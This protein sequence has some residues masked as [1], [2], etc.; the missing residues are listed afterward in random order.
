MTELVARTAAAIVIG[1]ELLSGK[2]QDANVI[3]LARTLRGLGVRLARV[4]TVPDDPDVIAAEVKALRQHVDLVLTSGGVGPTHDDVTIEAVARAFGVEVVVHPELR[5][6]LED[7]YRERCTEHHL[8]MA[9]VPAGAELVGTDGVHWPAIVMH[10]VWML[11]GVPEVF[12]AKLEI[13]RRRIHGPGRIFSRAVL[14][15]LEEAELKPH[16]DDVVRRFSD[17]EVG[18]YPRWRDST[19]RTKVT[20]DAGREDRVAAALE[21][22]VALLPAEAR[23][24]V[25]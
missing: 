21:A 16:L 11:P 12:R 17:V 20:F 6:L 9:L 8:R 22:F 25:E 3:E 4:V 24:S 23:R 14:T 19:Y 2:I 1:N 5:A 18:S 10:N 15:E 7:A 13:L